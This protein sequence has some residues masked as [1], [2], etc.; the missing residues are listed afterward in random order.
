MFRMTFAAPVI[1]P[2]GDRMGDTASDTS[3]GRPSL[4]R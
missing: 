3:I 2:V 1:S 4:V